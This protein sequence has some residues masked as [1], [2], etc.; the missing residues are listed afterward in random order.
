V[1]SIY[2][3]TKIHYRWLVED[4]RD[5]IQLI[6]STPALYAVLCKDFHHPDALWAK[7]SVQCAVVLVG[8]DTRA[9]TLVHIHQE[10]SHAKTT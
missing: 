10:Y 8:A 1:H 3:M 6:I 7:N 5:C 9:C 2:W 4:N